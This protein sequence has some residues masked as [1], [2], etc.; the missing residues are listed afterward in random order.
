MHTHTVSLLRKH[1]LWVAAASGQVLIEC[2]A[3]CGAP[4]SARGGLRKVP[5]IA[6]VCCDR[7]T[8]CTRPLSCVAHSP[9]AKYCYVTRN[10]TA[11]VSD[12]T[13]FVAGATWLTIRI[14]QSMHH[15]KILPLGSLTQLLC[16]ALSSMQVVQVVQYS[17]S[18]KTWH[19]SSSFTGLHFLVVSLTH[20]PTLDSARG[21]VQPRSPYIAA[22]V[23]ATSSCRLLSS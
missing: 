3:R 22:S 15:P 19:D 13:H 11:R 2:R 12:A 21:P 4:W 9:T 23:H 6:D 17:E 7:G 14:L 8:T 20:A 10:A 16:E 5:F 18:G 1:R